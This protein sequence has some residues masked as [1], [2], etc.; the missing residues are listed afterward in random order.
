M[1]ALRILALFL[2]F[3]MVCSVMVACGDGSGQTESDGDAETTLSAENDRESEQDTVPKDLKFKDE[4]FTFL[5]RSDRDIYKYEISCEELLNHPL[6]DAIHYRNIDVETRLEAKI[7][8]IGMLAAYPDYAPWNEALSVSV[9]TNTGDYDGAAFYLSTASALTKQGIYYNLNL[10]TDD[11]GG[12]FNFTKP[13]WN[14]AMV[15]ELSV[16]GA[17][18][19]AGGSL[20]VSEVAS[21]CCLFFNRDLFNEKYPDDKDAALYQLVRDGKWTV[22]LLIDYISQCW[23]DVNSNGHVDA[24]DVV[25]MKNLYTDTGIMDAWVPAMGLEFTAIDEYGEPYITIVNARTVPAYEKVMQV[26]NNEG[27]LL[28]SSDA[29]QEETSMQNGNLLFYMETLG[30]GAQMKA[31]EVNYGVL[32]LP[33]YDEVQEDY[34]TCFANNASA[35]AICSNLNDDRAAKVSAVLE[36]L[37]AESYKQ[38][39]PVYYETVLKGHYS[40]EAAD[41]EMY[42]RILSSFNFSFG[43]AYSSLSIG[44]FGALFRYVVDGKDVQNMIDSNRAYWD[45]QLAILLDALDTYA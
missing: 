16:Y 37:S 23:D 18:F 41:A 14:G 42:D 32:P 19:F 34:H 45:E 27:A 3:L 35:V 12:Y 28:V 22:D 20:T 38:V 43:F 10:L 11:E 8:S 9:L 17:L 15:D 36:L 5:V 31:S 13:W 40:R 26:F 24:G 1:K 33:K 6:Y 29:P 30:F 25:G 44:N 4:I 21:G 2:S 39:I 7:R